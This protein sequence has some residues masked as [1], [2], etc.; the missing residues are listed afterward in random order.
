MPA[1][2][3]RNWFVHQ[4]N[5]GDLSIFELMRASIA[6][7]RALMI[8]MLASFKLKSIIIVWRVAVTHSSTDHARCS[9][10]CVIRKDTLPHYKKASSLARQYK[11]PLIL[12]ATLPPSQG[13]F[14]PKLD[15]SSLWMFGN[16]TASIVH[17]DT[18]VALGWHTSEHIAYLLY[19]R[20]LLSS[21]DST[22]FVQDSPRRRLP[23]QHQNLYAATICNV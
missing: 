10:T 12:S 2:F 9:L 18:P 14:V 13:S 4:L 21:P 22:T 6:L 16:A 5:R 8:L 7:I 1:I 19:W 17:N 23:T 3:L 11:F 15:A 20:L